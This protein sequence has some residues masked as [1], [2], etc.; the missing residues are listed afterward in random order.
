MCICSFI[1]GMM[2]GH[3]H[4]LFSPLATRRF[5]MQPRSP[6]VLSIH[7]KK[8][9]FDPPKVCWVFALCYTILRN[10]DLNGTN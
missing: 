2:S 3:E 9:V 1:D 10:M 7:R 6:S 4:S 8:F 5:Y